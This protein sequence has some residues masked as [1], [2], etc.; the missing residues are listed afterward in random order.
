MKLEGKVAIITGAASGIGRAIA[1]MYG[2]EGAKV[3]VTDI[4]EDPREGGTSTHEIINNGGGEAIFIKTDVSSEEDV[5][6]MVEV[7]LDKFE[8]IDILVNNAGI[9]NQE[10]LH[11]SSF[12][13]WKNLLSVNLNGVYLC[14]KKV[15]NYMLKNGIEGKII[16]IS[17]IAGTVGYAESPGY[18]ASKGAITTLTK[19][20]ALD[21]AAE[22]INVNA[23]SPGVIKTQMTEQFRSNPEMKTFLE[24]NTPYKRLGEPEDIAFAAVFLASAGSNFI[25]GADLK[26]DGGW[27]AR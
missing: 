14:T 17:S 11:K 23:I 15:I 25:N 22:G 10:K 21:Y 27:T 6:K 8:R 13:N 7:T 26:V 12:E 3:I 19:E 1:K 18:C 2:E 9:F 4:K 20:L 16:N 5:D 24:Q